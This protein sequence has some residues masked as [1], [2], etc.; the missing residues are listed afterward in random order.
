MSETIDNTSSQALE[1]I[2]IIEAPW[3]RYRDTLRALRYEVF[4]QGQGVPVKEEWDGRDEDAHHWLAFHDDRPVATA[5]LLPS[6]QVGRMAV[7]APYRNRGLGGRLLGEVIRTAK[8]QGFDRLYLH[9]QVDAINFYRRAG[10]VFLGDEFWEAGIRHREM[11]IKLD[12]TDR[13]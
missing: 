4:V 7:I 1:N 9:A 2:T 6:G 11:E 12:N 10:F 3:P 8:Q 5:R 13:Q